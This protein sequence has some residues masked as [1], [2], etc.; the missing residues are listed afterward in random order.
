MK[1]LLIFGT[2]PE[3]IKLAPVIKELEKRPEF[4][5]KICVTAQHREMLDQVLHLFGIEPDWDLK[6][7]RESQ[8][9]FD[10]TASGLR[11]LEKVLKKEKPDVVLVQGDTTTAF[12][13][14]LAAYYLKIKIGHVEAGLR[15]HDKYNPFPEEINRKLVDALCDLWFA[16]TERAKRNLLQEG[17]PK[18]K[19][20]VTGNTVIDAL[21]WMTQQQSAF[22]SRKKLEMWFKE[23]YGI[24]LD[25]KRVILVTGHRRESFGKDF[26]DIC[27]G[28]KEIAERNEDVQLIY[29]VHLNPNVR[30]PVYRILGS[31]ENIHL[32]EPLDYALFVF[33]MNCAYLILTDSGG[34]Q[35]EAP[36]LGKP[37]LVMRKKTERPE[38]IEAGTAE[39]VGTE[40]E[41]IIKATQQLLDNKSKY[42]K[43]AKAVNPYGDGKAAERIVEIL[44]QRIE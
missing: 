40:A 11:G 35:E 36:S 3:A 6:L 41:N 17:V 39:I 22:S 43:M 25:E 32:I 33:L 42:E 15:T 14:S 38:A 13:A 37:V 5:T 1:V 27:H 20:F 28:L 4:K 2:R 19:V 21:L 12:V 10:I 34:I 31:T 16:P 24:L 26:E 30:E 9:L 23:R 7:M 44:S 8:T 18:G 29:P